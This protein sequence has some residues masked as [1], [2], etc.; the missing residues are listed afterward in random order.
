MLGF[1]PFKSVALAYDEKASVSGI[2]SNTSQK[3]GGDGIR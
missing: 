2:Y 3:V 1:S